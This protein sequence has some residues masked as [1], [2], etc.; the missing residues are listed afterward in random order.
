M[1]K[2]HESGA[3]VPFLGS[4]DWSRTSLALGFH[5]KGH[6]T[7]LWTQTHGP[8]VARPQAALGPSLCNQHGYRLLTACQPGFLGPTVEI[9]S[10][11]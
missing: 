5:G 3:S 9:D 4:P 10:N 8:S 1:V 2:E 11:L 6:F 7:E